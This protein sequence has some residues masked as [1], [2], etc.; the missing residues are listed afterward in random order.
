ML[1]QKPR[2]D[3]WSVVSGNQIAVRDINR[4]LCH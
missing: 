4:Y 3:D 2:M 1:M